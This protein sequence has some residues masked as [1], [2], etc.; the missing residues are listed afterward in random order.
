MLGSASPRKPS[1]AMD[2][3]ILG[4]LD[5]AGGVAFEAEQRVVA[6]HAEAVVGHADEAA[7]AGADFDGDFPGSASREFS[8]SSFTTLAGRSTTSPAA[9]WLAT[10]SERSLMRFIRLR[11]SLNC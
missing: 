5:F 4:A 3:K 6:A 11:E 8:T 10:C 9:I 7:S 2:A 1:V